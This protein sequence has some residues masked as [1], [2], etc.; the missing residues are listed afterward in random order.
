MSRLDLLCLASV[1][2]ARLLELA[3][4]LSA[5]Q[6]APALLADAT[7]GVALVSPLMLGGGHG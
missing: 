6:S 4:L 5:G 7:W 3:V 1:T 2:R